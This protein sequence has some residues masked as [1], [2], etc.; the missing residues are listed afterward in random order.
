MPSLQTSQKAKAKI[1]QARDEKG[2]KVEDQEPLQKASEALTGKTDW[3]KET[4]NGY[5][6]AE[7]VSDGTWKRF[8][9]G[10]DPIN[11]TVY[12]AF[13]KILDLKWE[14]VAEGSP[15]QPTAP[16]VSFFAAYNSAWVGRETLIDS[17]NNRL[18]GACRILLLVGITGIG[19]TALAERLAVELED[20]FE[21]DWNKLFRANFDHEDNADF[22][23]IAAKWLEKW[24]EPITPEERQEPQRLLDRVVKRFQR[25]KYLVLID[26][27]EKSLT[28]DEETGWSDFV[29]KWWEK[30]FQRLLSAESCQSRFI[31]TSQDLP[32]K[33]EEIG[34]RYPNFWHP[35]SLDGLTEPEQVELFE[36]TEL[37]VSPESPSRSLLLRIGAAYA[38]HPL[39]LWTIAGEIVNEPFNKNILAYWSQY[40]H[41]IQ[42]V[43]KALE[44]A[45]QGKVE[46]A[47]DQWKLD[48]YSTELQRKVK[49]RLDVTFQRLAEGVPHAYELLCIA[50]VYRCL[51]KQNWW[52]KH[53]Q[54]RG[55][56]QQMQE[57]AL[58]ALRDRYLV[59]ETIDEHHGR[60][61]G[62]HNLIRSVAITHRKNLRI[63]T[64]RTQSA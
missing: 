7:G 58:Q 6:Y 27:L 31:V 15:T 34:S 41:E 42:E 18:R 4:P 48:Q 21:S 50:S 11:T 30:F 29:D 16:P 64:A 36:K 1:K 49:S 14:E 19:K 60:L 12:K 43:E 63:T 47:T 57:S 2:W 35:K 46:S 28:G 26:S 22:A 17:L 5:L 9:Y 56:N 3:P 39:A 40:G 37:E 8:L 44:E 24:G 32:A 61:L 23:S 62:Q 38:G 33:L 20:W 59:E 54:Y 53:L 45:R 55:H 25:N 10:K 13:C 52:L 51:V